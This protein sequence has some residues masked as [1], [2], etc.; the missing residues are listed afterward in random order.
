LEFYLFNRIDSDGWVAGRT[1]SRPSPLV[2]GGSH[3]E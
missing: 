3:L 2:T 1:S